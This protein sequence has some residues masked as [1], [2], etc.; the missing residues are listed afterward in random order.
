MKILFVCTGNASRSAAAE[1]IMKKL[2]TDE[3]LEGVEVSS[4]GT[5]VPDGL[6]REEIMCRIA[7]EHGYEM[8]GKAVAMNEELLNSAD[9]IIVMT[10]WHHEKVTRLL[11]YDHWNRIVRFND[12]CFGESSDLPDPH[13][14][15]E[16]VYRT[17]FD[18]VEAGCKEIIKKLK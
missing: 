4:C 16:H 18:R 3:N 14:Q 8:G 13:Y 11:R 6:D 2:I 1:A 17:C 15:T 10:E 12:F 7:A 5:G 9:L